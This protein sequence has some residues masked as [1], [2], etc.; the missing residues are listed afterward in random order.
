VNVESGP[1][2]YAPPPGWPRD[3]FERVTDALVAALVASWRR[4]HEREERIA[5][6]LLEER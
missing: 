6:E 5:M 3:V 4:D 2:Q 1:R